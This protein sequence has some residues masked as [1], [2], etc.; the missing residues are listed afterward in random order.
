M[1]HI[2]R[3]SNLYFKGSLLFWVNLCIIIH[4]YLYQFSELIESEGNG[5]SILPVGLWFLIC[6]LGS[7]LWFW[8]EIQCDDMWHFVDLVVGWGFLYYF[9]VERMEKNIVP[10][11][12]EFQIVVF[13]PYRTQILLSRLFPH[14]EIISAWFIYSDTLALMYQIYRF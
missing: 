13:Y 7:R 2:I 3:S 14:C 8:Y 9:R 10:L 11:A 12:I 6:H 1:L 4:R 5:F